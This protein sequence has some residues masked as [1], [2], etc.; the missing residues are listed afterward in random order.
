MDVL[1]VSVGVAPFL[2][3]GYRPDVDTLIYIDLA[4]ALA[5]SCFL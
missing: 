5:G 4:K 3:V 1:I 2:V